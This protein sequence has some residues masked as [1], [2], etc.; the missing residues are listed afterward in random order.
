MGDSNLSEYKDMIDVISK[1]GLSGGEVP[2]T[3][4]E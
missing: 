2:K 1:N 3:D 4:I